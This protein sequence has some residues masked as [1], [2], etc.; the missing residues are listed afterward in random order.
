MTC[1]GVTHRIAPSDVEGVFSV[2]D[3][4]GFIPRVHGGPLP[5]CPPLDPVD[6][7]I[8]FLPTKVPYNPRHLITGHPHR[9][10]LWSGRV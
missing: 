3:W 5:V 6:R 8:D 7:L 2:L 4:L 10:M 1:V 9:G